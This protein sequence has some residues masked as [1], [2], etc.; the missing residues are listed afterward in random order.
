MNSYRIWFSQ[1]NGSTLLC[2]ALEQTGVAGKPLELF[3]ITEEESLCGHYGVNT[4]AEL[5]E[6]LWSLGSTPN[7]VMAVKHSLYTSR[8]QQISIE[9]KQLT[10]EK[11]WSEREIWDDMFPNCTH[12]FITRRN[13]VRQTVSWWK[14]INDGIWHKHHIDDNHTDESLQGKY[15]SNALHH[16]LKETIL[17]ECAIQEYFDQENI[18]PL[19]IVYEDFILDYE[20]T[21]HKVLGFLELEHHGITISPPP[22]HKTATDFSEEWVQRFRAELQHGW[23]KLIW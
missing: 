5:K 23:D 4:Y 14:A 19:T 17:R 13:K 16:L 22:L 2:K 6:K 7:G 21:I 10:S 18:N 3:N 11:K 15:N 9:L 8:H 1:R 20:N 12:I